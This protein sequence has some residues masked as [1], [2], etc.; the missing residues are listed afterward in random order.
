LAPQ[1]RFPTSPRIHPG[2]EGLLSSSYPNEIIRKLSV[3][4]TVFFIEP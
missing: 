2:K 1:S 3:A 4:E